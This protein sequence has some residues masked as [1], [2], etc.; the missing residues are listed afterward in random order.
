MGG[1]GGGTIDTKPATNCGTSGGF[2]YHTLADFLYFY[3]EGSYINSL[4]TTFPN[5]TPQSRQSAKRLL[6][7]SEMGLPHPFSR[8]PPPTL[9]SGGGGHTRLRERGWESPNADEGTDTVVLYIYKYFVHHT[10]QLDTGNYM[11]VSNAD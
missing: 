1:E 4:H 3:S 6:Q 11:H 10:L 8:R 9:W 5:T 2:I 7:S